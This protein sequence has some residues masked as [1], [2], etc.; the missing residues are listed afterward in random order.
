[1]SSPSSSSESLLPS[2]GGL[3]L[4]DSQPQHD[5]SKM[6]VIPIEVR[7]KV[8]QDQDH[9]P[10]AGNAVSSCSCREMARHENGNQKPVLSLSVHESTKR[11]GETVL[12]NSEW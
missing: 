12:E 9:H 1:M 6:I 8:S 10:A 5:T 7:L 2:S 11:R 4:I 3:E